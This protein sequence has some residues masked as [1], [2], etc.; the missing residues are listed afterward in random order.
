MIFVVLKRHMVL[1]EA[2]E[3]KVFYTDFV[4]FYFSIAMDKP[5]NF[6]HLA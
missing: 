5:L 2:S 4:A 6:F 1:T 3:L